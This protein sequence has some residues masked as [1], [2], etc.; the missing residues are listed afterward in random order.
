MKV[1]LHDNDCLIW[2]TPDDP[3]YYSESRLW[4]RIKQALIA[5]GHDVIKTCPAK[6]GN[7]TDAPYYI[8]ERGSAW[9]LYD[10]EYMIHDMAEAFNRNGG[11]TL[12]RIALGIEYPV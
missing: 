8:R 4:Y 5:R 1:E 10:N 9:A 7:L 3:K 12:Q 2:S 11:I 6:D